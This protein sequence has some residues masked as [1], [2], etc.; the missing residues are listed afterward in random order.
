VP[1]LSISIIFKLV[2]A[3]IIELISRS[4]Q[5][6]LPPTSSEADSVV[7]CRIA[8]SEDST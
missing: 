6:P 5:M 8:K 7:L 3:S 2:V 1:P 4:S